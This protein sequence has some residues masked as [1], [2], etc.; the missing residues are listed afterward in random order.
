M[1][2]DIETISLSSNEDIK[3]LP[4]T[5]V[6]A[7]PKPRQ[8]RQPR[9]T[10]A[11]TP[12]R[13]AKKP[14]NFKNHKISE[15]FSSAK[16]S[17][18]KPL[19]WIYRCYQH[20]DSISVIFCL[21]PSTSNPKLVNSSGIATNNP[22]IDKPKQPEPTEAQKYKSS[23]RS[24]KVVLRRLSIEKNVET[25]RKRKV[26]EDQSKL[27]EFI[28]YETSR[29]TYFQTYEKSTL[30]GEPKEAEATE[31]TSD[32]ATLEKR[33][34]IEVNGND[35]EENSRTRSDDIDEQTSK[36][37]INNADVD[38]NRGASV[39]ENGELK[40]ESST[41]SKKSNKIKKETK[42]KKGKKVKVAATRKK[43]VV[44]CPHYK[45]VEDTKLAVDAFRYGD[46]EGVEHYFLSHFH[47][48]HY[49]GLKKSFNHKLYV[50]KITGK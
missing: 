21:G 26:Q 50:S 10:T 25:T 32:A 2:I 9:S 39:T 27:P 41:E 44:E 23:L 31:Q 46:I 13:S 19:L 28:D 20:F 4:K 38:S 37:S 3:P 7:T 29:E 42:G 5:P 36:G 14:L 15:Y 22:N 16:K 48:D 35:F 18:C 17:D 8:K 40:S 6:K 33:M 30:N 12:S 45:I 11:F 49:I 1:P 34:K 24:V 47:A 43:K